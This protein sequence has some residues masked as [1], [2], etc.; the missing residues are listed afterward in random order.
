MPIR[1]NRSHSHGAATA[2][3]K[4]S[5][6]LQLLR[7]SIARVTPSGKVSDGDYNGIGSFLINPTTWEESK[8]ANWVATQV[9]GQS[10]PVMQWLSSGPRSVSF[11][12]LVTKDTSYSSKGYLTQEKDMNPKKS[13]LGTIAGAFFKVVPDVV[14]ESANW[15]R[16][17]KP[18]AQ[19]GSSPYDS[20]YY[21]ISNQL[22]FFRSLLYPI[23]D[24]ADSPK[25]LRNSPPL[26]V[27]YVGDT[28]SKDSPS[29]S[30]LKPSDDVWVVTNLRIRITK[31]LPNL[32][33]MEASVE[34]QLVQYNIRSSTAEKFY[35]SPVAISDIK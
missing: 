14:N 12:A 32:S 23:Y 33:P 34:F 28:F 27:L 31:Q 20:S 11:E 35:T 30:G 3:A 19:Q 8:A 6:G 24:D 5:T 10:D 4:N 21:S 16:A 2:A 22:N 1:P 25:V 29:L 13:I 15:F 26:V 17:A 9:P 7:A 18:T